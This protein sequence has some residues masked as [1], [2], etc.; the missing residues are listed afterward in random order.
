MR[1]HEVTLL[2]NTI[3]S[4]ITV[5]FVFSLLIDKNNEFYGQKVIWGHLGSF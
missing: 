3:T 5:E 1:S 2:R 4:M